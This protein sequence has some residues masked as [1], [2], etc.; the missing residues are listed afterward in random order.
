MKPNNLFRTV[1]VAFA[2]GAF[3]LHSGPAWATAIGWTEWPAWN[4]VGASALEITTDS[5]TEVAAGYVSNVSTPT[6]GRYLQI[7]LLA[8]TQSEIAALNVQGNYISGCSVQDTFID[9]VASNLTCVTA[10]PPI[11]VYQWVW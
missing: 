4:G 6:N 11:T 5:G 10:T 2:L 9:G 7:R 8:G 3:A 1:S